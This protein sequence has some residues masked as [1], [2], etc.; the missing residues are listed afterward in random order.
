MEDVR[1]A[2]SEKWPDGDT[3]L[4]MSVIFDEVLTCDVIDNPKRLDFYLVGNI[5]F[6]EMSSPDF[7]R[8]HAEKIQERIH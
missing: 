3:S 7:L 1:R 2:F 6:E 8:K 4:F 5:L